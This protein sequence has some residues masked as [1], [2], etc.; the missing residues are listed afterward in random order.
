M[1]E[2]AVYRRR[3]RRARWSRAAGPTTSTIDD[4][5]ENTHVVHYPLESVTSHQDHGP[6]QYGRC[7][8]SQV[9]CPS[10]QE[11]M[12]TGTFSLLQRSTR[13]SGQLPDSARLFEGLP[14]NASH[15][16]WCTFQPG[17]TPV[18]SPLLLFIHSH[19]CK[20]QFKFLHSMSDLSIIR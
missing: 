5:A 14:P 13:S 20:K 8:S 16:C 15:F 9:S 3:T 17:S 1:G 6:T 4:R 11:Q 18:A 12:L 19:C 10:G 7:C 2:E